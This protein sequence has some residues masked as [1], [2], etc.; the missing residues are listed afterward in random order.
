MSPHSK[1]PEPPP[2]LP[3]G[4]TQRP[5]RAIALRYDAASEPSAA[6]RV[7]ATGQGEAADKIL[8]LAAEHGVP[9]RQDR[10]LLELLAQCDVGQEI[11]FELYAAVAEVLAFLQRVDAGIGT[12]PR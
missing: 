1:D 7:V 8:A 11:P 3:G 5:R 9:V 2:P 6:P 4:T 10:E 12:A